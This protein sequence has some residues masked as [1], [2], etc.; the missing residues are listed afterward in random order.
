V[1]WGKNLNFGDG[2]RVGCFES[3]SV[4]IQVAENCLKSQSLLFSLIIFLRLCITIGVALRAVKI[5]SND[6]HVSLII[7]YTINA[8]YELIPGMKATPS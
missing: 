2:K 1:R 5:S 6:S 4:S 8:N 3:L 7:K